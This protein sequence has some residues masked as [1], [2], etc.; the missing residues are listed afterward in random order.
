LSFI[1]RDALAHALYQPLYLMFSAERLIFGRSGR[2]GEYFGAD[3]QFSQ[4]RLVCRGIAGALFR[5]LTFDCL[6]TAFGPSANGCHV[7][8]CRPSQIVCFRRLC[9]SSRG[10]P[11]SAHMIGSVEKIVPATLRVARSLLS[12]RLLTALDRAF[13]P[14]MKLARAP[15]REFSDRLE[16]EAQI[17]KAFRFFLQRRPG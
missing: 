1:R 12:Q 5:Q 10:Q 13:E 8:F 6:E 9:A 14:G 3:A 7:L 16:G 15:P 2:V 11:I 4:D 17:G